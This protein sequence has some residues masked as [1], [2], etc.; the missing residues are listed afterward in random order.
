MKIFKR[1]LNIIIEFSI[2][3]IFRNKW[4]V[5]LLIGHAYRY[6][7][8]IENRKL[9]CER[10]A[11]INQARAIA[12][13]SVETILKE[14]LEDISNHLCQTLCEQLNNIS[15][16]IRKRKGKMSEQNETDEARKV[17]EF[18]KQK[19]LHPSFDFIS[20]ILGAKLILQTY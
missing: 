17:A 3:L 10:E 5:I 20:N 6:I 16:D 8:A 2:V 9:V 12:E 7:K 11:L 4:Q 1:K 15:D 19:I 13:S 14:F 18:L